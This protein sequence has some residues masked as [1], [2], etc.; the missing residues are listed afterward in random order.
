MYNV[1]GNRGNEET[2]ANQ[3]S[4]SLSLSQMRVSEPE[5]WE[6]GDSLD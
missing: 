1:T 5:A 6:G 2:F 4:D 3:V